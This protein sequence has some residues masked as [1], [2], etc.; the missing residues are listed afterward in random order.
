MATTSTTTAE[1]TKA[2]TT[3]K[4]ATTTAPTI[5][6]PVIN[7]P[8]QT[9]ATTAPVTN[10]TSVTNANQGK[11]VNGLYTAIDNSY[12]ISVPEGW[13]LQQNGGA[14]QFFS[15]DYQETRTNM[16]IITSTTGGTS[17]NEITKEQFESQFSAVFD[18]L[19]IQAF[20]KLTIDNLNA[21]EII[22]VFTISDVSELENMNFTICQYIIE[23]PTLTYTVSY[24]C[25]NPSD[26][27][28]QSF[29]SN[30]QTFHKL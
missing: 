4:N 15:T 25:L 30:V 11:V 3:K 28:M 19:S 21:L 18:G 5:K 26:S 8:T 1:T 16:N 23:T 20:N 9:T 7:V 14:P 2:T 6:V 12:T 24:V 22:Y 10:T 17:I 13:T 29:R 27:L